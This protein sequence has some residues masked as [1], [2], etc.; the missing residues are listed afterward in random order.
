MFLLLGVRAI[1]GNY[2]CVSCEYYQKLLDTQLCKLHR[3]NSVPPVLVHRRVYLSV[4]DTYYVPTRCSN[5]HEREKLLHTHTSS[6][7]YVP[8]THKKSRFNTK[9]HTV[10]LIKRSESIRPIL[11]LRTAI[12]WYWYFVRTHCWVLYLFPC[13]PFGILGEHWGRTGGV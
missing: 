8:G 11:P 2:K 1:C 4:L 13:R 12:S 10:V 9:Q 3:D 6:I 5:P 7:Q